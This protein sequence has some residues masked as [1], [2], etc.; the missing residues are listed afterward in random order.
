MSVRL[1]CRQR[2]VA[3]FRASFAAQASRSFGGKT[4]ELRGAPGDEDAGWTA[5]ETKREGKM[6]R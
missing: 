6:K 4:G 1:G 5:G 3:N 2:R